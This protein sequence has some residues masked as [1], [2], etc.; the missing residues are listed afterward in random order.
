MHKPPRT[1]PQQLIDEHGAVAF[2]RFADTIARINGRAADLRTPMGKPA[3]SF[4]RHFH[5]KQFQYFGIISDALLIGCAFADTGWL[6]LAFVYVYDVRTK[7]LHEYTW[8][9]PFARALHMSE[10]PVQG[11]SRFEQGKVA[12]QLG[13]QQRGDRLEKTLR[14]RTPELTL[15]AGMLEPVDY[16]PMSICTR[17]GINGWTYANKVAGVAVT[18]TLTWQA[19]THSLQA[20]GAWGHHDFSAGYMRRETFWNWACLTGEVQG[21][22]VGF[23][24]SCGVNET[25]ETENC[26]WLDGQ[27]VKV[28]TVSFDYQRDDLLQRWQITSDDGQVELTFTPEGRHQERLDLGLFASNFNQLFGRFDGHLTLVDGTR[29]TLEGQYGFVEEQ[30]AK[31]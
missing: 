7:K 6:G 15:D 31:W 18:G 21:R 5:Y 24:L 27:L 12:I 30:F 11:E 1:P 28:S 4:A 26:L 2:G 20:L 13:Y 3:S 9:S 14:I 23:N 16:Q 25:S 8:R 17:T 22:A 29:L 10:S 19:Q